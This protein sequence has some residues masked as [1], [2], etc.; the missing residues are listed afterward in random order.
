[1]QC[2]ELCNSAANDGQDQCDMN[3]SHILHWESICSACIT[4]LFLLLLPL[5]FIF[6]SSYSSLLLP[7]SIFFS[8]STSSSSFFSSFSSFLFSLSLSPFYLFL[9][10]PLY[11]H[12]KQVM[13]ARNIFTT[14]TQSLDLHQFRQDCNKKCKGDKFVFFKT[15]STIIPQES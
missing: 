5:L 12:L 1:M 7:S 10:P 6:F 3:S 14:V 13:C 4:L 11:F 2:D 9:S 15:L 8:S